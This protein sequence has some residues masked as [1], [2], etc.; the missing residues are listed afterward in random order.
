MSLIIPDPEA[1]VSTHF[2]WRE[3]LWLPG[4]QR[5]ATE[6]DG[7]T[8]AILDGATAHAKLMDK[9]RDFF[10]LPV[11]THCWFRSVAYNEKV[12]G[13][14]H[15]AHLEGIATDFDIDGLT[16]QTVI[17]AILKNDLLNQY[18]LRMENNGFPGGLAPTW[19]HLDSR[20]PTNSRYF[21]P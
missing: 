17:N 14:I 6:E 18:G 15:S 3:V 21:L 20:A 7:L 19:V 10:S 1:F 12:G 5:L 8:Q 11:N 16:C 9:I 4:Y 2:R 13:A